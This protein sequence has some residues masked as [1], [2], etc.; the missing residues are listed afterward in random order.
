MDRNA[1]ERLAYSPAEAA[2]VLGLSRPMVY[3]LMRRADFPSFK[4]GARTLIPA[5]GLREWVQRQ[6]G[7]DVM[8]DRTEGGGW[9]V[10]L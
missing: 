2:V 7:V 9:Q 10:G 8:D 6:G 1:L 3:Q 4:V 5:E